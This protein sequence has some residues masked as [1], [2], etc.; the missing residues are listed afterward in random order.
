MQCGQVVRAS[1]VKS[2]DPEFKS[3]SEHQQ[4]LFQVVTGWT[5]QLRWYI[6]NWFALLPVQILNLFSSFVVFCCYVCICGCHLSIYLSE[7][8]NYYYYYYCYYCWCS[9][10]SNFFCPVGIATPSEKKQYWNF[11]ETEF[12]QLTN[13]LRWK[14]F[15]RSLEKECGEFFLQVQKNKCELFERKIISLHI[16]GNVSLNVKQAEKSSEVNIF[17]HWISG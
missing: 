14:G 3:C 17:R 11:R 16:F 4:D 9:F 12:L 5:H 10:G 1:N 7:L 8:I 15:L 13:D 6:A 2:G